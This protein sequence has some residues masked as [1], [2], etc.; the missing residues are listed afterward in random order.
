MQTLD[1]KLHSY[2]N[3]IQKAIS[4]FQSIFQKL[5]YKYA[6]LS[7]IK[8]PEKQ[9]FSHKNKII[10]VHSFISIKSKTILSRIHSNL[11]IKIAIPTL[12]T[13]TYQY[14]KINVGLKKNNNN[15]I[16]A[17]NIIPSEIQLIDFYQF[18]VFDSKILQKEDVKSFSVY[19]NQYESSL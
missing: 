14:R 2:F 12:N 1:F 5:I 4:N 16:L 19:E 15:C 6:S 10:I 8:E 3:I 11:F 7:I 17:F 9:S 18:V 13:I